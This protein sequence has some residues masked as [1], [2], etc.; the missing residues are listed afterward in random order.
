[1]NVVKIFDVL[2]RH[3]DKNPED[4][5]RFV[6]Y[7]MYPIYLAKGSEGPLDGELHS[8]EYFHGR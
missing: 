1:L 2:S 3:L 8:A 5:A 4:K 7:G 6:N